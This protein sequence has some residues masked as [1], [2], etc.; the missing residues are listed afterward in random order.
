[1]ILI[2]IMRYR[3]RERQNDKHQYLNIFININNFGIYEEYTLS[4]NEML[5][6]M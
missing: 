3:E 4:Q 1:M 2:N 5:W 6:Q